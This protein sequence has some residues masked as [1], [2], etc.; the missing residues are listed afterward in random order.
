MKE[1]LIIS[2][3]TNK[4]I[5]DRLIHIAKYELEKNKKKYEIISVPGAFEIPAAISFSISKNFS[6]YI[7]LGCI[8][9]S[10]T[11]HFDYICST[12]ISGISKMVLKHNLA[13]GFGLITTDDYSQ[14]IHRSDIN[15]SNNYA[16]IAVNACLDMIK[17]KES[18]IC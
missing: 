9:R 14:A 11:P 12:S 17:V 6:G 4:D 10:E 7:T 13:L 5:C 8:I 18:F 1:I 3:K 16:L 15:N 2:S